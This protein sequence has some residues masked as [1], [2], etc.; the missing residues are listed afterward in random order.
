M[1]ARRTQPIASALHRVRLR[2]QLFASSS[3]TCGECRARFG[4]SLGARTHTLTNGASLDLY[5]FSRSHSSPHQQTCY[6]RASPNAKGDKQTNKQTDRPTGQRLGK[7]SAR[8]KTFSASLCVPAPDQRQ[9]LRAAEVRRETDHRT[10]GRTDRRPNGAHH[11]R[12][13]ARSLARRMT[14]VRQTRASN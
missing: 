10:D 7:Q 4:H 5:N 11:S 3:C 12:V 14:S 2:R 9:D 13:R 6:A 8:G 1:G